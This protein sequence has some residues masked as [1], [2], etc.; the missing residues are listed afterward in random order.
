M[1]FLIHAYSLLRPMG[2]DLR[3]VSAAIGDLEVLSGF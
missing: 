1:M 2:M 3:F